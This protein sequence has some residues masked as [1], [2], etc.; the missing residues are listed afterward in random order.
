MYE[1][2]I[3]PI[4]LSQTAE[5]ATALLAETINVIGRLPGFKYTHTPA[6]IP[7]F[8][9]IN[10]FDK[11]KDYMDFVIVTEYPEYDTRILREFYTADTLE[12][13]LTDI[14][15]L[16]LRPIYQLTPNTGFQHTVKI[17]LPHIL[18]LLVTV[19]QEDLVEYHESVFHDGADSGLHHPESFDRLFGN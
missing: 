19:H 4:P 17:S 7:S 2:D 6:D 12:L 5:V 10:F 16:V 18:C 13:I 9:P 1:N 15:Y 14:Q 11:E 3:R 8:K